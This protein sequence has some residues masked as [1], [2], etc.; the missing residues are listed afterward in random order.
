[1]GYTGAI[2]AGCCIVWIII[3]FVQYWQRLSTLHSGKSIPYNQNRIPLA[4]F[5]GVMVV[6]QILIY[7]FG[8]FIYEV[9]KRIDVVYVDASEGYSDGGISIHATMGISLGA[10]LFITILSFGIVF[11]FHRR[12]IRSTKRI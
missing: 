7:V 9:G 10:S 12:A 4:F 1:M 8:G 5:S 11:F 3:A 2:I 6:G